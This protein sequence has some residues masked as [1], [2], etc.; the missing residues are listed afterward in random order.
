MHWLRTKLIMT[1]RTIVDNGFFDMYKSDL[2]E[3]ELC[4]NHL[5]NYINHNNKIYSLIDYQI[6]DKQLDKLLSKKEKNKIKEE[7]NYITFNI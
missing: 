1:K 2:I 7:N 3:C 6:L 4:K 5:L